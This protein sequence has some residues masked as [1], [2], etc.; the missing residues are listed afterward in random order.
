MS[1]GK[2]FDGDEVR[3]RMVQFIKT[4]YASTLGKDIELLDQ[5]GGLEKLHKKYCL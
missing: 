3:Q 5:P 4:H 2:K 1:N